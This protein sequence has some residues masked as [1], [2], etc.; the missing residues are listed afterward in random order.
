MIGSQL[1]CGFVN[2]MMD[3]KEVM[4][5]VMI[6]DDKIVYFYFYYVYMLWNFNF[7][8]ICQGVKCINVD[9]YEMMFEIDLWCVWWDL[10]GEV[11]V[12]LL[13]YVKNVY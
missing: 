6:F 10:I 4:Y 12:L 3:I 8:V 9:V 5:V 7:S 11:F 1:N 2:I 13:S